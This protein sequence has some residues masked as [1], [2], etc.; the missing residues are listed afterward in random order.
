VDR[1][2]GSLSDV[3]GAGTRVR[4]ARDGSFGV[5]VADVATPLVMVL[6]EIVQNAVEHGFPDDADSGSVTLTAHRHGRRV[7]VVVADDGVGLPAGFS[8]ESSDRLG[9]QIVRTL[10]TAELGGS[11]VVRPRAH[12]PGTEAVLDVP[13]T[14]RR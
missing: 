6:T 11:I 12:G 13:L 9:L 14:R 7:T 4:L 2:L 3:A 10:V 5:L 8:L 1:L